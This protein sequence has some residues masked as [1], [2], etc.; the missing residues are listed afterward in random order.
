ML[1]LNLVIRS[2]FFFFERQLAARITFSLIM[3]TDDIIRF[4]ALLF[5]KVQV[6]YHCNQII[7]ILAITIYLNK[8]HVCLLTTAASWAVPALARTVPSCFTAELW[9]KL[10]NLPIPKTLQIINLRVLLKLLFSTT[11]IFNK[12]YNQCWMHHQK[13]VTFDLKY[14]FLTRI[15]FQH[16]GNAVSSVISFTR[17]FLF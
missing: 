14:R 12:Y 16:D 2:E 1:L 6:H 3:L 7:I 15:L 8:V 9:S 13:K 10:L 4:S 11:T 17:C 5:A